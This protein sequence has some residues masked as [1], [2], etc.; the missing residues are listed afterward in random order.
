MC[1][2]CC[3]CVLFAVAPLANALNSDTERPADCVKKNF[4]GR[5]TQN[6]CGNKRSYPGLPFRPHSRADNLGCLFC[7]RAFKA[8]VVHC[9]SVQVS[10]VWW[11]PLRMWRGI[12]WLFP[13]SWRCWGP[14]VVA[15][16]LI[17]MFLLL[18]VCT[19]CCLRWM[20]PLLSSAQHTTQSSSCSQ[21]EDR[22]GM[23]LFS[24]ALF[25]LLKRPQSR[26]TSG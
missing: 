4:G 11:G 1:C 17:Q 5:D 19:H 24:P 13:L 25:F 8:V 18:P 7:Q 16:P 6:R 3:V 23:I 12:Q 15:T 10:G 9:V 26:L 2:C 14:V 21:G 22:R 20:P